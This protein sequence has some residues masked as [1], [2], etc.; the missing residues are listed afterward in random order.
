M[1]KVNV[2][3]TTYTTT[4]QTLLKNSPN[5]FSQ[6][7]EWKPQSSYIF[8]D[9][10][11]KYFELILQHIRNYTIS[12][13]RDS[14]ELVRLYEECNFYGIITLIPILEDLLGIHLT[15][16]KR[17]ETIIHIRNIIHTHR[18][19]TFMNNLSFLHQMSD[20]ELT[21]LKESIETHIE[22]VN[23]LRTLD[24]MFDGLLRI[25]KIIEDSQKCDGLTNVVFSKKREVYVLLEKILKENSSTTLLLYLSNILRST[26]II[27][28]LQ[29]PT[30]PTPSQVS[31]QAP[32]QQL[33][34]SYTQK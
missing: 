22:E 26:N 17:E 23:T 1:I 12:I 33:P 6:Y 10:D 21:N 15:P 31:S 13:P 18:L 8:I 34:P 29:P 9:R 27:P 24:D 30:V 19:K 11:P 7:L 28:S 5:Y 32:A 2:G 14:G 3:G 20:K 16:Q 25:C 4:R